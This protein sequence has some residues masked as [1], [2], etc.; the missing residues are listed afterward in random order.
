MTKECKLSFSPAPESREE[1]RGG[2]ALMAAL[3]TS[4]NCKISRSGH[5]EERKKDKIISGKFSTKFGPIS[6]H[7]ALDDGD[8]VDMVFKA[9][10]LSFLENDSLGEGKAS[11]LRYEYATSSEDQFCLQNWMLCDFF[12]LSRQ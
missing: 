3:T 1:D 7:A 2:S 8:G 4:R 12:A 10:A 6:F 11:R 9:F 5:L